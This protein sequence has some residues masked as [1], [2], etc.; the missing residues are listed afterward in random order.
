M[1]CRSPSSWRAAR[2]RLLSLDEILGHMDDRPATP[3]RPGRAR[4]GPATEPFHAAISWSHDL[5][6]FEEQALFRRLSV[7]SGGFTWD[8]MRARSRLRWRPEHRCAVHRSGESP[9]R[10]PHG[11]AAG[12][13][14]SRCWRRS[15]NS[16]GPK[17]GW[18]AIREAVRERHAAYYVRLAEEAHPHLMGEYGDPSAWMARMDAELGNL[19]AAIEWLLARGDGERALRLLLDI[20]EYTLARP[21]QQRNAPG[22]LSQPWRSRRTRHS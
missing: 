18:Q 10:L 14:V 16:G 21:M 13:L 7:F 9:S 2:T 12:K 11:R 6:T 4:T 22:G 19:R 20:W 5:L 3:H 1:G 15:A 17:Y 8:A